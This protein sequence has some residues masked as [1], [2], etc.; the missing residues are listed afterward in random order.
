MFQPLPKSWRVWAVG[1]GFLV[2]WP[3]L[4]HFPHAEVHLGHPSQT[5]CSL[6]QAPLSLCWMGSWEAGGGE[7][8]QRGSWSCVFRGLSRMIWVF[9]LLWYQ[10]HIQRPLQTEE[11]P[12]TLSFSYASLE[13]EKLN[14][15]PQSHGFNHQGMTGDHPNSVVLHLLLQGHLGTQKTPKPGHHSRAVKAEPREGPRHVHAHR[16]RKRATGSNT[17]AGTQC[18]P[19]Q[20]SEVLLTTPQSTRPRGSLLSVP[21]CSPCPH[22]GAF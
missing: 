4:F 21:R 8:E 15:P 3:L 7:R 9:G 11:D 19:G 10:A 13:E 22:E 17:S 18:A 14:R 1:Q 16:C 2:L 12:Y 5:L 6:P 20:L